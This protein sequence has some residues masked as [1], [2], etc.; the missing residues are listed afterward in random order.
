MY[1][2]VLTALYEPLCEKKW[3]LKSQNLRRQFLESQN[4]AIE[5]KQTLAE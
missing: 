3:H 2:F 5:S 4:I 1:V